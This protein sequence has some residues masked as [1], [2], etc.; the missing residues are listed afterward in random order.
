MRDP[1]PGSDWRNDGGWAIILDRGR[2]GSQTITSF[3]QGG[4]PGR[5]V[6]VFNG[7]GYTAG[8]THI[9]NSAGTRSKEIISSR[10]TGNNAYTQ[11]PQWI[12]T[13]LGAHQQGQW[14]GNQGLVVHTQDGNPHPQNLVVIDADKDGNIDAQDAIFGSS[15]NELWL[16][17]FT[18]TEQLFGSSYIRWVDLRWCR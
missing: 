10:P 8:A 15:N 18:T 11:V 17:W 16:L 1:I 12:R 13:H 9:D 7:W 5:T 3:I 2:G 14:D 6:A 4:S